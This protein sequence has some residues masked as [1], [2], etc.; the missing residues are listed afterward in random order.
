M[1]KEW[2]PSQNKL[3]QDSEGNEKIQYPIPDQTKTDYPKEHKEAH[4]NT[5]QEKILQEITENFIEMFLDKVN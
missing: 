5:M 3:V 2:K 1:K 4:K